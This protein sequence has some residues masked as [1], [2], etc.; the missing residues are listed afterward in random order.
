[1]DQYDQ[2]TQKMTK[3]GQNHLYCEPGV[4]RNG[5]EMVEIVKMVEMATDQK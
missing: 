4:P 5:V 3:N 2:N 1:M